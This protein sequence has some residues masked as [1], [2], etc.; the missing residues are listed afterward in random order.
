MKHNTQEYNKSVI[1]RL[2]KGKK[3]AFSYQGNYNNLTKQNYYGII[4]YIKG[5]DM[6]YLGKLLRLN[7]E[8]KDEVLEEWEHYKNGLDEMGRP[9]WQEEYPDIKK[10]DKN[11]MEI[12]Q[13]NILCKHEHEDNEE[14]QEMVYDLRSGENIPLK[15]KVYYER[16][17]G[18]NY[19]IYG[20]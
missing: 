6:S 11:I 18:E 16:F 3:K 8:Y 4:R 12:V 13:V 1:E 15:E 9:N 10:T 20:D 7:P 19:G 14:H 2:G 17:S 5:K